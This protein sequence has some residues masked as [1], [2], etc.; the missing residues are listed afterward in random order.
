[1]RQFQQDAS[2]PCARKTH[3]SPIEVVDIDKEVDLES[4]TGWI[5]TEIGVIGNTRLQKIGAIA[6]PFLF[7]TLPMPAEN[8][9]RAWIPEIRHLDEVFAA[10]PR[11]TS[12]SLF[13]RKR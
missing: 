2:R 9:R 3:L 5:G 12:R 6:A 13:Y 10:A 8:L 1:M 7:S 11:H 4:G